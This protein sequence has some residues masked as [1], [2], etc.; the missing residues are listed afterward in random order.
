VPISLNTPKL[1]RPRT[2]GSR[3]QQ[4]ALKTLAV[5]GAGIVLVSAV[6]VSLV[7][8]A[9][10]MTALAVFGGYLWWKTRHL[11]AQLRAGHQNNRVIEGVVIREVHDKQIRHD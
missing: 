1:S 8:F 10:A 7:L 3:V 5:A 4:L 11:R 6:A 9:V 2:A